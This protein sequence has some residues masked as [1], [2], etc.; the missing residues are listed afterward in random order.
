MIKM[1]YTVAT[2]YRKGVG[3]ENE[4]AYFSN[5]QINRFAVIDGATGLNGY[6]GRIAASLL[7]ES[8]E[9]KHLSLDQCCNIASKKVEDT[10]FE[11]NNISIYEINKSARSTCGFVAIEFQENE[12]KYIHA[13][14]CM[15]FINYKDG[16]IR[17]VTYDHLAKLDSVSIQKYSEYLQ[18]ALQK[19]TN[20]NFKE[21]QK[22]AFD[23]IMPILIQN[24]NLLNTNEGYGAFDGTE[25]S[26]NYFDRGTIRLQNISQILLISDGLQIPIQDSSKRDNW[27]ESALFAFQYGIEALLNHIEAIEESDPSCI[28]YPRLKFADDKTGIL[29]KFK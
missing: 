15:L 4:D 7:K 25:E 5:E 16:N 11:S 10:L 26:L 20:M 12:L 14:D 21:L 24:R 18:I 17:Q 1:N 28:L 9:K 22:N 8:F 27:H 23:A 19:N 6:S 2:V 3:D 29:I 13:G